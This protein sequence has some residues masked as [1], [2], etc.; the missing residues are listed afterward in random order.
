MNDLK[1]LD[2]QDEQYVGLSENLN[3]AGW[4]HADACGARLGFQDLIRHL[5][6]VEPCERLSAAK[7]LEHPWATSPHEGRTKSEI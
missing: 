2:G 7:V 4:P 6:V 5:L 3:G 1:M